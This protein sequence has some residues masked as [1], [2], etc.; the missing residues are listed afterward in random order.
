[1]SSIGWFEVGKSSIRGLYLICMTLE[2]FHNLR[3]RLQTTYRLQKSYDK[4]R[5]RYLEFENGDKV[6][7]KISLIKGVVT[8]SKKGKIEPS[9]CGALSNI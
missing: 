1:M 9:L 5:I 8:F 6:Y 3:N 4:D 7:L 2:N